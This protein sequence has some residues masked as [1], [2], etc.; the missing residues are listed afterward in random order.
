MEKKMKQSKIYYWILPAL[1][2]F[3]MA[4][5]K[6][7]NSMGYTP[8]TGTP[9]ISSVQTINKYVVGSYTQTTT[10]YS[11]SGV[12]TTTSYTDT[13][14]KSLMAFDSTTV[15]GNLGTMYKI[16]GTN[17]GSATKLTLNGVA[18]YFNRAF[19]DDNSIIFMLPT[20]VPYVQPQTNAM[21]ITTLHG[22]VT[23]KFTTLPPPPTIIQV[24]DYDFWANSQI[25][26]SGKGFASVSDIKLRATGD[27]VTILSKIDSTLVLQ[28]P[29]ASTVTESSLLFTY[30]SGSNNNAQTASTAMFNDLDNAYTIFFN[31]GFQNSW[32]DNS[33]S[34]PSGAQ[35][36]NPHAF[37]GTKSIE[38]NYPAGAWQIEGWANWWPGA[39]YD[40]GYKYLTFW[41]KGG[42]AAHT[43]VLVGDK[44][45]GG[46]GQVQNANAY[47]GQLVTVPPGVWTFV[48]I[49]LTDPST[50]FSKTSTQLNYWANGTPANQLGFFLQGM[51]G[52][53]NETM[54]FDEVAFI[55]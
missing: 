5:C 45:V 21:V 35:S 18:I 50:A 53:V 17:L 44:M 54:Y 8:G 23:Y 12:I 43:L 33:W 20:N 29:S 11:S 28:M 34:G 24:S 13:A 42:K 26:L 41:V 6:K 4:S 51:N 19:G 36:G 16:N 31:D 52:D 15:T 22:S 10:T 27:D 46:Y 9:T 40:A 32:G 14:H 2:V 30:T 49:P 7:D 55:K 25:T 39:A 1:V 48:K 38:A 3:G 47:A 37:G